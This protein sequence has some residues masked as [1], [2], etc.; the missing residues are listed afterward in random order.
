MLSNYCIIFLWHDL[1]TYILGERTIPWSKKLRLS[2]IVD[3][4]IRFQ[5][6][7]SNPIFIHV[8]R[9]Q[10]IIVHNAF[11]LF[12][13]HRSLGILE[14]KQ[15]LL[16][17]HVFWQRIFSKMSITGLH[18]RW[19]NVGMPYKIIAAICS[20]EAMSLGQNVFNGL[21]INAIISIFK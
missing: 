1:I 19:A 18:V 16:F 5:I 13:I 9:T 4:R 20:F 6:I 11:M 14:I 10:G 21:Y 2:S 3:G 17:M 8:I 7:S 12:H 15:S